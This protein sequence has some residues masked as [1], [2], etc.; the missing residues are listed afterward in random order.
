MDKAGKIYIKLILVAL[1]WGATFVAG[2]IMSAAVPPFTAAFLRFLLA[3]LVLLCFV[4]RKERILPSLDKKQILLVVIVG[5]SGM[6]GYNYC[7]FSGLATIDASRASVIV[8]AGNPVGIAIFSALLLKE[9]LKLFNLMGILLSVSGAIIVISRGHL[10]TI[11]QGG[12]GT[13]DLFIMGC[14][15]CWITFTIVGKV[16][17]K[18]LSPLMLVFYAS[19]AATIMLFFP[20]LAEGT[21][22][23]ALGGGAPIWWSILV[24]GFF[25]TALGFTWFYDGVGMLG[26]TRAGIFINFVP[27]FATIMAVLV[28]HEQITASFSIGV[29]MVIAGVTLTNQR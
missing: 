10:A 21:L 11:I 27:V 22:L 6:V 2:R 13:G 23:S 9:R 25:G 8:A 17:L 3:T 1:F 15:A 16:G 5:L 12:I 28:L 7:F 4:F 19:L 18:D 20:A 29:L 14:V 26:P 24:L